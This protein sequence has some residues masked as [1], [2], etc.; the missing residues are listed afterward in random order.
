MACKMPSLRSLP[1]LVAYRSFLPIGSVVSPQSS[2]N[3]WSLISNSAL[4]SNAFVAL[5]RFSS[6]IGQNG[7][8]WSD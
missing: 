1:N 8:I 3:G 5:S 6:P 2:L 7:Q 4:F